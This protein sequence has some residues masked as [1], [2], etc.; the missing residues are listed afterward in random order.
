MA[1][2]ARAHFEKCLHATNA[3]KP[4]ASVLSHLVRPRPSRSEREREREPMY[5]QHTTHTHKLTHTRFHWKPA[6]TLS[7]NDATHN[8]YNTKNGRGQA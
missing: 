2:G 6:P 4:R 5:H 7:A 3:Q 1:E 8:S